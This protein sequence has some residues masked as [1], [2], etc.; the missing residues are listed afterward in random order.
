MQ[1]KKSY[2]TSRGLRGPISVA[3]N[4]RVLCF[5]EGFFF[6]LFVKRIKLSSAQRLFKLMPE[7]IR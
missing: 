2:W 4:K 1:M 5:L 3:K 7:C 6:F